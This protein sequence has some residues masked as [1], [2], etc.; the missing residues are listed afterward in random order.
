MTDRL[1]LRPPA[2]IN[3]TLDV[4]PRRGDGFHDVRTWMQSIAL[5][6]TLTLIPWP[7]P[8]ALQTNTPEAPAD[9]TNLVWRAARL[10]WDAL[11][12]TGEPEGV[13]ASLEK[14]IPAGAG[15]GGGSADAAAALVGL[16]R[17]WGGGQSRESL[18][19][20]AGRLGA[21]VSFFLE[22][23]LAF[24]S[25]KGDELTPHDDLS[26]LDVVVISPPFTVATANAYRWLDEDRAS[27]LANH[28]PGAAL[29]LGGSQGR[30]ALV[31]HLQPPVARRHPAIDEM[32][33]A[34]ERSGAIGAAMTGSG[35]AVFGLFRPGEG[36]LA[37]QG[38][39]RPGWTVR[40]TRFLTRREA[41]GLLTV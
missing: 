11:G 7:G 20:L 25:G 39:G 33:A 31:N 8:F 29:D 30:L 15:L 19:R 36:V 5:V 22:G 12:R 18:A 24:G 27:G 34:C 37:A 2:K 17:L 35:S 28:Q 41:A 3:L 26:P 32:V 6:D 21:D 4:G 13:H 38:L 40:A 10:L 14:H 23:G 1:I 9:P 16:D